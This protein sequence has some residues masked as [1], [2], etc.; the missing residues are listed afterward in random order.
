[1]LQHKKEDRIIS[2]HTHTYTFNLLMI[3]CFEATLRRNITNILPAQ[4][5][6]QSVE[7]TDIYYPVKASRKLRS[8][9]RVMEI[10]LVQKEEALP[11][12]SAFTGAGG[13]ANEE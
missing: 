10:L 2:L 13:G 12:A 8:S 7:E 4:Q 3:V 11:H 9:I 1:M 5:C 6:S